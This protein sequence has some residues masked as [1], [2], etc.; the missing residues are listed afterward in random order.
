MLVLNEHLISTVI[1]ILILFV[2]LRIFLWKPVLRMMEKRKQTIQDSLDDAARSNAEAEEKKL[3]YETKLQ[4]AH[5]QS[6]QLVSQAKSRA[7]VQYDEIV[8]QANEDAA[9][10]LAKA[11]KAALA[12]RDRLM[13][14]AQGELAQVALAAAAKLL[15]ATVNAEANKKML[16][17]FLAEAG[18]T[19]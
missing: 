6:N 17:A 15:G 16:D 7:Q 12:D 1:N 2:L 14:D 13:E 19:K 3:Q 18:G 5:Q 11:D 10:I 4:D 9:S 8:R